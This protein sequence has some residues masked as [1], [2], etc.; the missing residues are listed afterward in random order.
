M[1]VREDLEGALA[2]R[3]ASEYVAGSV[4]HA[5]FNNLL[6]TLRVRFPD[7]THDELDLL[8][9]DDRRT[10]EEILDEMI[11]GTVYVDEAV[12]VIAQRFFGED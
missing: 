12:D 6:K 4:V 9:A 8:L 2:T 3:A 11:T 10:T 5:I 7:V 1:S